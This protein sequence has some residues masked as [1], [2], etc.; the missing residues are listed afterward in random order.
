MPEE[1]TK[2]D[3]DAY[4]GEN[5]QAAQKSS[6]ASPSKSPSKPRGK[7]VSTRIRLLDGTEWDT[8]IEVSN[9]LAI[10]SI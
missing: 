1:K 9:D 2:I 5:G 4:V 6:S 8:S 3:G 7:L 10:L